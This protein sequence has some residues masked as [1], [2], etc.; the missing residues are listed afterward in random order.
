MR[1]KTV[2]KYT[3]WM[4]E[5]A[6]YR[7]RKRKYMIQYFKDNKERIRQRQRCDP[8]YQAKNR[9]KSAKYYRANR[10]KILARAKANRDAKRDA[11]RKAKENDTG[12]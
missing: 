10:D 12:K 5:D 2:A 3:K 6:E 8:I 1:K 9:E 7:E 4:K 11:K